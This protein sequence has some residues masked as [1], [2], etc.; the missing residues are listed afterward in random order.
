[1]NRLLGL[2]CDSCS[3]TYAADGAVQSYCPDCGPEWGTLE[4]KYDFETIRKQFRDQLIDETEPVSILRYK[5]FL[6]FDNLRSFPRLRIGCTPIY[7]LP[8]LARSLNLTACFIKDDGLNPTGSYKDRASSVVVA[9]AIELKHS[10]V[11]CASTGNAAASL[12]GCCAASGLRCIV[13]VPSTAPKAKLIQIGAFGA[14]LISVT[15][16]YDQAF[17]LSMEACQEY[18]WFNRSAGLNPYLVEG[19]K[20]GAFEVCETFHFDPP[21]CIFVSVGDGSIITGLCK[22]FQEFHG[23]GLIERVPRIYGVQAQGAAPLAEAFQ[24]FLRN[25][26]LIINPI[27]AHTFADS[28]CVGKPREGIRAIKSVAATNGTIFSV[29]DDSIR[30]ALR[31]AASSRG[32]FCE[33]AGATAL[34]GMIHAAESGIIKSNERALAFMTGNGL[35]DITGVQ[36]SVDVLLH[37]VSPDI[38]AFKKITLGE[39][40]SGSDDRI[41]RGAR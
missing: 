8:R 23:I 3:L 34:A 1:M 41:N 11:A 40:N 25:G 16:S 22:G 17:D 31:Y 13:F 6:P 36:E 26:S 32:I 30:H 27:E 20:T 35:K 10:T 4:C 2:H 9:R 28:I 21:E 37:Q 18:G 29:S 33:P 14:H 7:S 24:Q 12:A 38:E 19:K 15:G 39:L 5:A